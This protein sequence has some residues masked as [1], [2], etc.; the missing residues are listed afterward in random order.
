[1]IKSHETCDSH[2]YGLLLFWIFTARD[3]K[4]YCH[5]RG[6]PPTPVTGPVQSPGGGWGGGYPS[7]WSQ[8][9]S[10]HCS[11]VLSGEGIPLVLSTVLSEVPSTQQWYPPQTGQGVPPHLPDM[12]ASDATPRAVRLLWSCKRT[13]L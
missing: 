4:L 2:V 6:V 3:G 7:L 12:R 5:S 9:P 10:S 8:V 11:Q 13:F 1:M